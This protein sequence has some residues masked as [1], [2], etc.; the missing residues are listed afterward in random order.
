MTLAH[1]RIKAPEHLKQTLLNYAA[2]LIAREGLGNLTLDKVVKGTG[3]SKGGLQHHFPSKNE[4][5][6]A[7]FI[8]LQQQLIDEVNAGMAEDP[9]PTGRAT[10]AYLNAC[11]RMMPDEEQ[12]INRALIA[13]ML[14]DPVM[15]D[16]WALF[17]N[18]VLPMDN[19]G[20]EFAEQLLL[21]RLAADGLWFATLCG[22]HTITDTQRQ[23]LLSRLLTLTE[24][25]T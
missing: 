13:A 17:I 24:K 2:T 20:P 19:A 6:N 16:S 5:I 10:R 23:A 8:D 22:Y 25:L 14:G 11:A 12:A 18:N 3:I 4:L 9:N 15:R 7:V 1:H 21:C